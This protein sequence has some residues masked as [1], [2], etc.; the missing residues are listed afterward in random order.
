MEY[1]RRQD[2]D[3][4][5]GYSRW[6]G[7][8]D[9]T[10]WSK[11]RVKIASKWIEGSSKVADLGCG[12]QILAR[13]LDASCKYSGYDIHNMNPRNI[14]IDLNE[15][16]DLGRVFD[17]AIL[18]GVLE[19]LDDPF[20]TLASLQHQADELI[21]SY[22]FSKESNLEIIEKRI[23]IGVLNHFGQKEFLSGLESLGLSVL[24]RKV[25]WDRQEDEHI[26]FHLE[27]A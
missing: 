7:E 23:S 3:H 20:V 2:S 10:D 26:I 19:F 24:D 1:E 16:F 11:F 21:L 12:T 5:M 14:L 9:E 27:W 13:S 17:Y 4:I 18:L 8:L 6:K 22:V 25:I 15:D